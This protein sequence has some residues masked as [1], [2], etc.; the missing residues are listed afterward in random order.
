MMTLRKFS[1]PIPQIHNM[2]TE[3]CTMNNITYIYIFNL[4]EVYIVVL[5]LRVIILA[6][7]RLQ[8]EK[9]KSS[10]K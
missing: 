1:M 7:V 8:V 9:L 4:K 2:C 6:R 10:L 5:K 3:K